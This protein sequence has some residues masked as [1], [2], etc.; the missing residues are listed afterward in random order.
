MWLI[1]GVTHRILRRIR[2]L[3]SI[4]SQLNLV[5][6]KLPRQL[7]A[8]SLDSNNLPDLSLRAFIL[9]GYLTLFMLREDA[10]QVLEL[11]LS[12]LPVDL[13]QCLFAVALVCAWL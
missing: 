2:L 3:C 5:E 7:L 10:V 9:S 4:L 11:E 1:K 8:V 12:L 6:F 13:A